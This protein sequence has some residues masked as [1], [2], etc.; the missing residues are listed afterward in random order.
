VSSAVFSIGYDGSVGAALLRD[1]ATIR[2]QLDTLL[3]QA[4]SGRVA[5]TYAGLGGA[6][7]ASLVLA[8]QIAEQQG[9][10]KNI[11]AAGAQ[12]QVAQTALAQI[13]SI[14]AKFYADTNNLNGLNP[15][16][17]DSI[18]VAAQQAL[19]QVAGLLDSTDGTLYVFGG[20][21]STNPPVPNPDGILASGF[22]TQIQAV[23][24]GLSGTGAAG[25]IASTRAIAASNAAGTSPFSSALSQ[26]ATVLQAQ[27]PAV[28]IGPGQQVPFG[29]PASANGFV[30]STGASTTGSYMRDVLRALATLGSLASAQVNDTGFAAVVQDVH[31]SLGDA[32]TALNQD[33]G[34]LG[35][36]Q[37][38]LQARQSALGDTVTALQTQLSGAQD[39]DMATTLSQISQ[40]QTRLQASYEL[41]SG[42]QSYSLARFLGPVIG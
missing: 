30:A 29:I 20:Q 39:A 23:V 4:G 37:T 40:T 14:A 21:D 33:A 24:A 8:P 27:R 2:Q 26:P 36:V 41:L 11:D 12:M 25:V 38:A 15:S 9:W 1:S 7:A 6:A 3:Q 18:A 31:S 32:I 10:Q 16:E 17:V 28:A 19:Q 34:A 5:D 42:L 35:D 22:F 13:S